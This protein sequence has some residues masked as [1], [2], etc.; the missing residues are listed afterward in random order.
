MKQIE[1]LGKKLRFRFMAMSKLIGIIAFCFVLIV[2]I[3]AMYEM[4]IS[5]DYSSLS[6]LII[7][8]FGFASVY[9]GFY[10]TMAKVEHLE[11]EKTRREMELRKLQKQNDVDEVEIQEKRQQIN[12]T[13][14]KLTELMGEQTSSLL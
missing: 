10:L 4:H 14:A 6:Q 13:I 12:D 1:Q 8:A 2:T 3:Y 5:Q 9:A 11:V 7:S